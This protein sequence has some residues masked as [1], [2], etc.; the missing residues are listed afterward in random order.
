MLTDLYKFWNGF[1]EWILSEFRGGFYCIFFC[2]IEIPT[3]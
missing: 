3:Y 2:N 1:L